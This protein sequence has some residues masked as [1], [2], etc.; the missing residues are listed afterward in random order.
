[1]RIV[2]TGATGFIGKHLIKYLTDRGLK[3][4]GVGRNPKKLKEIS[5]TFGI[6]SI[7][8]DIKSPGNNRLLNFDKPD[9]VIHLAWGAL[10]NYNSPVHIEEELPAHYNFLK[11][12]ITNGAKR[13]IVAGTCLEYGL[14]NGVLSEDSFTD[15]VT[16]YAIAKDALRRYLWV[17]QKQVSYSLI[18]LRYFYMYGPGQSEKSL[19]SQLDSAINSGEPV[20]NMS[21]GEQVRD[22][23]AIEEAARITA[24][25][26]K[27]NKADGIFNICSGKPVSI[28]RLVEKRKTELR[29][30][31]VLNLGAV[32]YPD[33]EPMAFWGDN[34]KISDLMESHQNHD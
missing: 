12:L 28:R 16:A 14:Q 20:F 3:P 13:V 11:K 2:V 27:S 23:L 1:M 8:C 17:L 24:F 9:I 6:P 33:Y 21:K 29:S 15:P 34:R 26:A 5:N 7:E 31:I 18:W 4:I 30:D 22:Y 25:I 19:L 10:H 32:A